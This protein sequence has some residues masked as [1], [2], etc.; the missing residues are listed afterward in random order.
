M[1]PCVALIP[2]PVRAWLHD[3]AMR[4]VERRG[5]GAMRRQ[6]LRDARGATLEIGA[7][8]GAN[9]AWYPPA[10]APLT[11]TDPDAHK[12]DRLRRRA[13]RLRPDARITPAAA[14][15]LPFP[16]GAFDTVIATLVLCSVPNQRLALTELRRVLRPGG[17]L[18]FLEH[19]RSEEPRL[20]RRQDRWRPAWRAV[21]GGCEPNRDTAA[22]ISAAG[23]TLT[24]LRRLTMPAGP[25]IVRPLIA[26][27]ATRPA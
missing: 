1:S 8:T 16:D 4:R 12:L 18:L 10:A 15:E 7:G 5:L 3:R 2:G 11:L 24:E 21:A 19:V 26:G 9:V 14:E 17:R 25:S 20:A 27:I 23:L 13:R 22:A 6:V